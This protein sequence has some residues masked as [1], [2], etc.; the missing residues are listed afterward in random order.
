MLQIGL[1]WG[2]LLPYLAVAVLVM[3]FAYF[4]VPETKDKSS[5]E[6]ENF[7]EKRNKTCCNGGMDYINGDSLNGN[8]ET[9]FQ[10]SKI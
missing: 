7:Y 2:A 3:V 1:K 5:L 10:A 8:T 6:I 4:V 9:N